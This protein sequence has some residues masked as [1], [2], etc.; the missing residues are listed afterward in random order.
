MQKTIKPVFLQRIFAV[1]KKFPS[2]QVDGILFSNISNI[3]Y[4]SGFTGSDGILILSADAAWLLVDGRYTTQAAAEVQPIFV[5]QYQNK[6]QGIEKAVKELGLKKI[7]F[8]ASFVSV[9]MYNDLTRSLKKTKLVPLGDELRLLRAYKDKYEI[10]V[11]KKRRRLPRQRSPRSP[12]KYNPAGRSKR[13][14]CNWK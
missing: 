1:Q 10:A 11:M 14:L 9:E 3:R 13:R 2:Y 4:L 7:G 6:I 8:E 12:A 5:V